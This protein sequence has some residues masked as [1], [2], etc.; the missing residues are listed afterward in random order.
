MRFLNLSRHHWHTPEI[1]SDQVV[2][3]PGFIPYTPQ[4]V[5]T[6][7]PTAGAQ[8]YAW[9][10]Y[11]LLAFS[12]IGPT[13]SNRLISFKPAQPAPLTAMQAIPIQGLGGLV[14]G[15]VALQPLLQGQSVS[16][17]YEGV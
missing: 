11:Q 15:Q 10:T 12:P 17:L 16:A 6:R 5:K 8:V 1:Q 4:Y 14:V 2:L 13:E 3:S 9:D 7:Q